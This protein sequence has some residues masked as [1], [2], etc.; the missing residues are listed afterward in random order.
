MY[1][2]IY[3][4]MHTYV[5]IYIYIHIH[6]HIYTHSKLVL[7]HSLAYDRLPYAVARATD[8]FALMYGLL[9]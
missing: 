4:Y 8:R 7:Y 2:Y 5:C 3:I 6:A 9:V 1:V